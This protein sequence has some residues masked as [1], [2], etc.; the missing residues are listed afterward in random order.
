MRS[1]GHSFLGA[2]LYALLLY[3]YPRS[4]R[5]EYGESMLQLFNDQ[6]RAVSGAGGNVMLWLKTLR[7]LVESV[8]AAYSNEHQTDKQRRSMAVGAVFVWGLIV[9]L[10]GVFLASAVVIPSYVGYMPQA[11]DGAAPIAAS[12]QALAGEPSPYRAVVIAAIVAVA[13]LLAAAAFLFSLA[14]RSLLNGAAVFVAGALLSIFLLGSNPWI[15]IRQGEPSIAG[16]WILGVWPLAAIAWVAL[17]IAKR[18]RP[19]TR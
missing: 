12:E 15:W 19:V 7:D 2:R 14:Q 1:N 11:V 18:Q 16:L 4:F 5:R 8:P 9:V 13:T 6:R 3:L 10:A 17:T